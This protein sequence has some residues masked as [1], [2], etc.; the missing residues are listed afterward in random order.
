MSNTHHY[1]AGAL[2]EDLL[3]IGEHD[4]AAALHASSEKCRKT[5]EAARSE[6]QRDLDL[7]LMLHAPNLLRVMRKCFRTRY[8]EGNLRVDR[9]WMG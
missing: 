9:G 8:Y 6:F 7:A 5:V 4:A 1:Y 3:K 2:V